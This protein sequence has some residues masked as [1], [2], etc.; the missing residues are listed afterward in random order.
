MQRVELYRFPTSGP[1]DVSGLAALVERGTVDPAS[2][3]CLRPT[4]ARS[5]PSP[6]AS[7]NT[8]RISP[9]SWSGSLACTAPPRS[10]P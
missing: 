2:I 6:R 1:E 3:I 10:P 4:I 5:R 7:R 9:M 8:A